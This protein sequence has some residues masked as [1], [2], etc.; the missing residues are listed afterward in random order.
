MSRPIVTK[1]GVVRYGYVDYAVIDH[2]EGQLK[3]LLDARKG[4]HQSLANDATDLR[5]QAKRLLRRANL[6][7]QARA[8]L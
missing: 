2:S 8:L 6:L 7:D 3:Q 5:E 4:T 1:A